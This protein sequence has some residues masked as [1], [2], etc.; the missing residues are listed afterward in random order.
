MA[1]R[2]S[3]SRVRLSG[4]G[5]DVACGCGYDGAHAGP[6]ASQPCV[7]SVSDSILGVLRHVVVNRVDQ[8]VQ[9]SSQEDHVAGLQRQQGIEDT[10]RPTSLAAGKR[11]ARRGGKPA[12]VAGKTSKRMKQTTSTYLHAFCVFE[13]AAR[14]AGQKERWA[15]SASPSEYGE[16]KGDQR[17]PLRL[18]ERALYRGHRFARRRRACAHAVARLRVVVFSRAPRRRSPAC[19][20]AC[21]VL[22]QSPPWGR[23][24]HRPDPTSRPPSPGSTLGSAAG[25][26]PEAGSAASCHGDGGVRSG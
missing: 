13:T 14:V 3:V 12:C 8:V 25:P 4:R 19:V 9:C 26:P 20:P 24:V 22:R 11:L 21:V 1:C 16:E 5:V 17:L 15:A 2:A 10:Q 6:R 7:K 18:V 23:R